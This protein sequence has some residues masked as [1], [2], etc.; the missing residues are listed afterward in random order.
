MRPEN[1]ACSRCTSG[2][3]DVILTAGQIMFLRAL[4]AAFHLTA[5][6]NH[7]PTTCQTVLTSPARGLLSLKIA[8]QNVKFFTSAEHSLLSHKTSPY[9]VR[10][11]L[12][13]QLDDLEKK[14]V[15]HAPG[16]SVRIG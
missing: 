14:Y 7:E 8:L 13:K 3:D 4:L 5:V 6:R 1:L 12:I 9:A 16:C 15:N 11:E 10:S 2:A